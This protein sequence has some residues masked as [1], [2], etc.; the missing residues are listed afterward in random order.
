MQ[1]HVHLSPFGHSR[2]KKVHRCSLPFIATSSRGCPRCRRM[3]RKPGHRSPFDL[4][5]DQFTV[6]DRYI[7][8][9]DVVY[10]R[11]TTRARVGFVSTCGAAQ[12]LSILNG[13]ILRSPI[14]QTYIV[15]TYICTSASFEREIVRFR[16]VSFYS[17]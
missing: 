5:S 1:K 7:N 12:D 11:S 2:K 16:V 14:R 10:T 15:R 17:R 4:F 3:L 6:Y 13:R 9:S 8:R